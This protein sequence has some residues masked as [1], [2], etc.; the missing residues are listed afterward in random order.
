MATEYKKKGHFYWSQKDSS[1]AREIYKELPKSNAIILDPFMGAGSSLFGITDTEHSFIGV[2]INEMPIEIV[3]FH[4]R[5]DP[6]ITY[7]KLLREIET[8]ESELSNNYIYDVSKSRAITIERVLFKSGDYKEILQLKILE[9][10]KINSEVEQDIAREISHRYKKSMNRLQEFDNPLLI[11]NSRIAIKKGT[12]LADIFSPINFIILS[13]LRKKD[14]TEDFKFL[15]GTTLHLL[16]LTD[17]KSQSQFPYW[18]PKT[19]ILDRNIFTS[20]KNRLEKI[21]RSYSQNNISLV[22]NQKRLANT[23]NSVLIVNKPMQKI[24]NEILDNSIDFVL[25]DPPYYDQVAYSEYLKIWEHF[26]GYKANTKD[27]IV[28]SQRDEDVSTK[29]NYLKNLTDAFRQVYRKMKNDSE[30][31]IY[32]KDSRIEN[33]LEILLILRK[34]GFKYAGQTYIEKQKYTYKQNT[35]KN[36][37]VTGEN[38]LKFVK[39]GNTILNKQLKE[40]NLNILKELTINYLRSKRVATLSEIMFNAIVKELYQYDKLEKNISTKEITK[41]LN[42][43]A[44]YDSRSRSY[45]LK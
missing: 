43:I 20:L 37:T 31:W 22:S 19:E 45:T 33:I 41:V 12:R 26:L 15:L 38:I 24:T 5:F 28:V 21:K 10:I 11:A 9:N 32:F 1:I 16:K 18:V 39:S 3:K 29:D 35:S 6:Q 36:T 44:S 2:E 7:N 25:T 17:K 4:L 42:N 30:M 13:E 23:T 27:E 34:L 14:L 40:V 8:Y